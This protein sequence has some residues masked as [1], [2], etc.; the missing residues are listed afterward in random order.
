MV[1]IE[2]DPIGNVCCNGFGPDGQ[3]WNSLV[4][5]SRGRRIK[6][7]RPLKARLTS[8]SI[9]S[10]RPGSVFCCRG[11]GAGC[12]GFHVGDRTIM[13]VIQG[14]L[15]LLD[16]CRGIGVHRSWGNKPEFVGLAEIFHSFR[17]ESATVSLFALEGFG[18]VVVG[19]IELGFGS[20]KAP[21]AAASSSHYLCLVQSAA[22]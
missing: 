21:G 14:F 7:I 18:P 16:A 9:E 22:G 8:R 20:R 11:R 1:T 4:L 15:V 5:V 13:D 3:T 6:T 12:L 10:R 17:L 19:Q 2:P